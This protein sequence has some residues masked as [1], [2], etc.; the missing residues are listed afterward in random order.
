M[1]VTAMLYAFG[2]GLASFVSPCVLPLVPIY[3][4]QLVGPG[5]L[6][7]QAR[8]GASAIAPDTPPAARWRPEP[9]LHAAAF[10]AGFGLAFVALGATASELGALLATQQAV[11]RRIGGVLLVLF[12]LHVA[13]IIRVPGLNRERRFTLRVGTPGYATSLAMGLVFAIGWTPC[14]GPYL[15]SILVLAAAAHTLGIGVG[16]LAIYALGLGVPFLLVGAAFDRLAPVL[17]RLSSSL[18]TIERV[19]GLL[20]VALGIVVFF[21]WLLYL[22][23]W[24]PVRI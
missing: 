10:V 16:L 1:T 19:A 3:I 8:A 18:P 4:A 24:F 20:L 15:A 2:V 17:K 22:N 6:G 5:V 12:G 11:L 7:S 21:N 14:V 23:S 13:G 9:L